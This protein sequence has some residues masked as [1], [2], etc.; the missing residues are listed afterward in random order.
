MT[1]YMKQKVFSWSDR[2]TVK[3]E[4][5][6]DRYYVEG[7][8]FS[9]GHKLHVFDMDNQEAAF[10]K[11]E[12]FTW[13]PKFEVYIDNSLAVEV[14]K[15]LTFFAQ[16]YTLEG[17]DWTVDGDL[18]EHKYEISSPAGSVA[19]ITKAYF[20]W[21]DSYQIDIAGGADEVMVLATVLAIDCVIADSSSNH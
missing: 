12:L 1:L 2:F 21:G 16:K 7:E 10:I 6:N 19:S 20:T 8:L 11:Q 17:T 14:K 18:W 15:E 4:L 5:G 9:W 3:D 13:L